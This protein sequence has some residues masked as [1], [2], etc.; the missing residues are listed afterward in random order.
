VS[1][2]R[3][4]VRVAEAQ[5]SSDG[6]GVRLKRV[7]GTRELDH[8]DPFLLLDEFGSDDPDDYIGGFPEHPH[9]GFETVTYMLA[10][11][12]RHEDHRGNR[13]TLTAGS[14]QWMTAGRGILHSEMPLQQAGLMRGFQLWVNLPAAQKMCE[15]RYQDIPPEAIPEVVAE[16]GARVRVVA[17][18]SG[19][20]EGPVREIVTRPLF[21]DVA[22]P[23]GGRF[24]HEVPVGHTAFVYVFEGEGEIGRVGDAPGRLLRPGQLGVLGDGDCVATRAG[25]AGL[26]FLLLAAAP[27]REPIARHGPFVMNTDAEIRQALRDLRSGTLAG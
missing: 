4:V 24:A 11:S 9:R 1:T 6:A 16:G 25:A 14:A 26:R 18:R 21:I 7:I 23:P 20:V 3:V 13:G 15:P 17:G 5:D 27:L 2:P 8:L 12:M 10:G 19:A 22:V